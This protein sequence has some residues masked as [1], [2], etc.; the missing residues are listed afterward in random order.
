MD[1]TIHTAR[2]PDQDGKLAINDETDALDYGIGKRPDRQGSRNEDG[3]IEG[4]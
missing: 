3:G 1:G 4:G 2:I